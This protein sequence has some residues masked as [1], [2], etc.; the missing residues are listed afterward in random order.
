MEFKR[1]TKETDISL[2]LELYGSGKAEVTT[3]V[4]FF[5]HMITLLAVHAG[6]DLKLNVVGDLHVDMHHTVE[7]TGI[8][9]GSAISKLL[10]D[11]SGINRYG[12]FFVPMDEALG[13]CSL[14][15]SG[16]P[17]L[18]L[19]CPLKGEKVGD[20]DSQML[21]EFLRAFSQ[22]AGLTLHLR[23]IYGDNDHHKV[24][25]LFK[26]LAHAVKEAISKSGTNTVLSSKGSLE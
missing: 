25:A 12:S 16:R 10:G 5:D 2:S 18:V 15:F 23:L 7:D 9:L 3:G 19:D 21:V 17:Y 24:E 26:A 1:T 8:V 4:G 22:N 11:K 14:D 20:F 13:F 6:F